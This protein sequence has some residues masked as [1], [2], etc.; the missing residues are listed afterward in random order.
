MSEVEYAIFLGALFVAL[1]FVGVWV[2]EYLS[3]L[4]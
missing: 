3:G 4:K 1:G 2:I